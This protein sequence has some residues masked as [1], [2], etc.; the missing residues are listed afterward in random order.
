[1]AKLPQIL[2]NAHDR[3]AAIEIE[4]RELQIFI[5]TYGKLAGAPSSVGAALAVAAPTKP[6][7]RPRKASR[8]RG[9]G[10]GTR[11]ERVSAAAREILQTHGKPMH[12]N[13]IHEELI[14][15]GV[16]LTGKNPRNNLGAVLSASKEFATKRGEGWW[17]RGEGH[18]RESAAVA[19]ND[20]PPV[21]NGVG[22]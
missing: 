5:A 19:T 9:R 7:E 8:K 16:V 10:G 18:L 17:F 6:V 1:M 13:Q 3:L 2:Q 20:Q 12:L 11:I 14:A 4:K 21:T 22:H 15:R